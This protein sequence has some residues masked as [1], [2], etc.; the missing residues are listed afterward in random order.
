MIL[1]L[2]VSN[3]LPTSKFGSQGGNV[4]VICVHDQSYEEKEGW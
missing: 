4:C 3:F 1:F 2:N